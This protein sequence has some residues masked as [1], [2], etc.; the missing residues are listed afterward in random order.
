VKKNMN[1]GKEVFESLN[2]LCS[3][4]QKYKMMEC[5]LITFL[6][7]YSENVFDI[8]NVDNRLRTPLHNASVKADNGVLEGLLMG[9]AD[10]NILDKDNCTPLCLAIWEENFDGAYILIN[11]SVDVNLGGGIFGSPMHLAV[12]KLEIGIVRALILK[13]ADVNKVDCDGN[14]PLHLVMNV[15]S[16]NPQKCTYIAETLVMNGANANIKNNDNWAPLHIAAR[17]G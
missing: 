16:K 8:N 7:N 5:A 10:T 4:L 13:N 14:T 1:D 12:V 9:K 17:K 15:F 3:L 6:E 2:V 11:S